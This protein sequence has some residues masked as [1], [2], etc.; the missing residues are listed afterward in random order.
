MFCLCCRPAPGFFAESVV[1]AAGDVAS[2]LKR[3][4]AYE[5]RRGYSRAP[6]THPAPSEFVIRNSRAITMDPHIG[7]I[8]HADI[9]V[10]DGN[11]VNVGRALATPA[12]EIDGSGLIA[13]PGFVADHRH[14]L[15]EA[16][17]ADEPGH[18]GLREAAPED[19]YRV[20]RLALLDLVSAGFTSIHCCAADIGEGHAETALLALIDAGLRGRFSY[21]LGAEPSTATASAVTLI[22]ELHD[23]WFAT[24]SGHLLDLG[25][26]GSSTEAAEQILSLHRL[27][28]A[29]HDI[30]QPAGPDCANRTIGAARRLGLDP[31]IG[32][33]SPGKC[34]D[35]ILVAGSLGPPTTAADVALVCIDGRIRKR[36]GILTE[37]NEG[38]I[39]REGGDA[40]ARLQSSLFRGNVIRWPGSATR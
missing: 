36:N 34:A 29:T 13:L 32:S 3:R 20:L 2:A 31:W 28:V 38:L 33:L 10:R 23:T 30:V 24:P 35:L 4:A 6:A 12:L 17:G 7:D 21:P 11:I 27:P 22:R 19:I 26:V 14:L 25:I 5:R 39:R 9:H 40:L 8:A 15:D 16:A 18:P 1:G 37:P